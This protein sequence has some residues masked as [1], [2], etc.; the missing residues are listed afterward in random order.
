MVN[1]V[2]A[3]LF[4]VRLGVQLGSS[5]GTIYTTISLANVRVAPTGQNTFIQPGVTKG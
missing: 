2:G 5:Y 1:L 4:F 3:I